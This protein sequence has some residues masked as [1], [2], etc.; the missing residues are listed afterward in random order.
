MTKLTSEQDAIKQAV[1][2]GFRPQDYGFT[3]GDTKLESVLF[4]GKKVIVNASKAFLQAGWNY[5]EKRDGG[6]WIHET[7][8]LSDPA[9]WIALGKARGWGIL[10]C[11]NCSK[12]AEPVRK[13]DSDPEYWADCC[14]RKKLNYGVSW[15]IH[16]L[17]YFETRLSNRDLTAFWQS[18]P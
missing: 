7:Q 16:A 6:F 1:E 13:N 10:H 14:Q 11:V 17:R 5:E 15:K 4:E 9:F 2:A 18:L 3:D 12:L 8:V